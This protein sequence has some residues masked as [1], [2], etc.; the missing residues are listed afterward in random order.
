[1]DGRFSFIVAVKSAATYKRIAATLR[2]WNYNFDQAKEGAEILL[3][4]AEAPLLL[5]TDGLLP[6]MNAD[7]LLQRFTAAPFLLRYV[8]WI[9]G[10]EATDSAYSLDHIEDCLMQPF[11]TQELRARVRSGIRQLAAQRQI[12]EL[13]E[14]LQ[15]ARN[16]AATTSEIS[17]QRTT[18][19]VEIA[20]QLQSEIFQNAAL[21]AENIRLAKIT[22]V[23]QAAAALRHEI[24]NPLFVISGSAETVSHRLSRQTSHD[25]DVSDFLPAVNRILDASEK[26]RQVVHAFS[27]ATTAHSVDYLPGMPMIEISG[28]ARKVA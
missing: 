8:L 15:E 5:I 25:F 2:R 21:E 9:T 19:S 3:R 6:D 17:H 18:Q 10:P 20:A 14:Q 23:M 1:M 28:K 7:E 22:T 12:S 26:I 16:L 27:A 24:N 13:R 11:T 4:A